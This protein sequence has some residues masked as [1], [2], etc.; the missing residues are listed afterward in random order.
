MRYREEEVAMECSLSEVGMDGVESEVVDEQAG[1]DAQQVQV[2]LQV[3]GSLR[4]VYSDNGD[5]VEA[6][7]IGGGDSSGVWARHDGVNNET[8]SVRPPVQAST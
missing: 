4:R 1:G 8:F 6:R 2:W 5:H 3:G 7:V